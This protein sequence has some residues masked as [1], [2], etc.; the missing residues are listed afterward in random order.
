MVEKIK[1]S[2][3]EE[4]KKKVKVILVITV[5]SLLILSLFLIFGS[6]SFVGQAI[7]FEN[8]NLVTD[9][10]YAGIPPLGEEYLLNKGDDLIVPVLVNVGDKVGNVF[11]FVLDY[12][13]NMLGYVNAQFI[14]DKISIVELDYSVPGKIVVA[15]TAT[16]PNTFQSAMNGDHIVGLIGLNFNV[17][18]ETGI[19][20][21]SFDPFNVLDSAGTDFAIAH[22]A[23]Y[24]IGNEL[25][26]DTTEEICTDGVDNDAD[27]L[28][29]FADT[30]D[31]LRLAPA[32]GCGNFDGD[33]YIT[34][35]DAKLIFSLVLD[36]EYNIDADINGDGESNVLDA[37]QLALFIES[38]EG[39]NCL[40]ITDKDGD[41]VNVADDCD[42]NDAD[43]NPSAL[44]VCDEVDNDC[45]GEVDE[46][47]VCVL[48]ET[49]LLGDVD[50]VSGIT[51][52]DA[53][54]IAQVALGV[55]IPETLT[56][57]DLDLDC[58]TRVTL[59]DAILVA[60]V[61]LGAPNIVA[62]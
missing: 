22:G 21:I 59:D 26:P 53:I 60:Q 12:D 1:Q 62:C 41:G 17:I 45:N 46:G 33:D 36:N 3:D 50:G 54:L 52:N 44:E 39:L 24:R 30:D 4:H 48:E 25:L 18:A 49:G 20:E 9:E 2:L 55:P 61:A 27:G 56:I 7:G 31:C 10:G 11:S 16:P 37:N 23:E 47:N 43:V 42:D 51:L 13:Q 6:R 29:D 58:D 34:L 19:T 14:N 5:L 38:G 57:D 40:D 32:D 28:V 35:E 15:G 8:Y